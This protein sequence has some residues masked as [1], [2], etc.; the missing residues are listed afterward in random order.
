MMKPI[1]KELKKKHGKDFPKSAL[2]RFA[3]L[4]LTQNAHSS[5]EA[6]EYQVLSEWLIDIIEAGLA[7]R[8]LHSNPFD[9]YF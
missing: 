6:R 9:D 8:G 4:H 7:F 2:S 1:I 5:E 3:Q